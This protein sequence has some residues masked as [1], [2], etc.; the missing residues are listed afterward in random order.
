MR[1]EKPRG[2]DNPSSLCP[3]GLTV[4]RCSMSELDPNTISASVTG[5]VDQ[6]YAFGGVEYGQNVNVSVV[7][8]A[9]FLLPSSFLPVFLV[10][11]VWA[12]RSTLPF[13]CRFAES[14]RLLPLD[15]RFYAPFR[16]LLRKSLTFIEENSAECL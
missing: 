12:I 6:G 10:F 13:V 1:R 4:A 15:I 11:F 3:M 9:I 2:V 8:V 5:C 16:S 7:L 14:L